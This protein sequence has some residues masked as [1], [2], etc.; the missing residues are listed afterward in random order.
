MNPP[1]RNTL[2]TSSL[3]LIALAACHSEQAPTGD[4]AAAFQ[5]LL[6]AAG[7]SAADTACVSVAASGAERDPTPAVLAA[8][9]ATV[10]AL[11]PVSACGM[12]DPDFGLV[13]LVSVTWQADT[14]VVTGETVAEH[15][16]RY[17]CRVSRSGAPLRPCVTTG[18]Q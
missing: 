17:E 13:R 4:Q 6:R 15:V 8:L 1:R 11:R 7:V 12:R 16:T 14:L 2:F 5:A 9:R 3:A 10:P 18:H